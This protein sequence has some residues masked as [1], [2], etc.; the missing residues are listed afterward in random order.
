MI[1]AIPLREFDIGGHMDGLSVCHGIYA[2]LAG[3]LIGEFQIAP[4]ISNG[5]TRTICQVSQPSVPFV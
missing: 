2:A 1:G 3:C 4:K 5:M